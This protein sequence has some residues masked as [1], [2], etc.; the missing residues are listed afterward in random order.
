[1][2]TIKELEKLQ[3]ERTKMRIICKC[4]HSCYV[5]HSRDYLLCSHC[6]NRVY[7]NKMIEFKYKMKQCKLE[8]TKN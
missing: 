3:R 8:L 4:G 6:H 2:L 5:P 7:R 1:M